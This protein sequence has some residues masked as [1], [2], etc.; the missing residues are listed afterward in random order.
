MHLG[1]IQVICRFKLHAMKIKNTSIAAMLGLMS[2]AS[3][4]QA[5]VQES[6][7]PPPTATSFAFLL[8]RANP[9]NSSLFVEPFLHFQFQ[10]GFGGLNSFQFYG[11][12]SVKSAHF[13]HTGLERNGDALLHTSRIY[14]GWAKKMGNTALGL[15]S[16]YLQMS[17]PDIRGITQ[18]R[19]D[20]GTNTTLA[21]KLHLASIASFLQFQQKIS[22]F[23]RIGLQ[24]QPIS[25]LQITSDIEISPQYYAFQGTI[26]YR[27][28][29][30]FIG[31][32]GY[33]SRLS[34]FHFSLTQETLKKIQ[35]TL[36]VQK[37]VQRPLQSQFSLTYLF[38]KP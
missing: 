8:P 33:Y 21:K 14:L 4:G 9:A 22:L 1:Q 28:R 10:R 23:G 25:V 34:Q 35:A 15:R 3:W 38:P 12:K 13:V 26:F 18:G 17:G 11:Q 27:F 7:T 5:L 37:S 24:Y 30:Q 29:P 32:F 31:S 19:L 2:A 16:H 20:V 36:S 6:V